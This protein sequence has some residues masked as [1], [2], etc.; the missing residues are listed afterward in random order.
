MRQK[1]TL[2]RKPG[3]VCNKNKMMREFHK[4][5]YPRQLPSKDYEDNLIIGNNL[6]EK[7][8]SRKQNQLQNRVQLCEKI[9]I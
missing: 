4:R 9:L 2:N 8:E 1:P 6:I 3:E 7:S 5:I